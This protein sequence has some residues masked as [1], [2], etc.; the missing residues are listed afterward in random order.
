MKTDLKEIY[1]LLF[2]TLGPQHWWPAETPFEVIVGAVLVQNTN[3]QNVRQAIDALR[4]EELLDPHKIAELEMETL[5]TLI[6]PAGYFRIK[7]RR[8]RA[9][10]DWLIEQCDGELDELFRR[11]TA[12]LRKQL[13][14]VHGVGPETAD[15][16]LLYA[17]NLPVF[18]VDA[19]T[20]RIFT[21]HGWADAADTD[22]HR[23]QERIETLLPRDTQLFNEF[24][25]M[26]VSIG[27][28]YCKKSS[29]RCEDCPLRS[30]LPPGGAIEI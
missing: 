28:T 22:Y 17:G 13:L 6:R 8:L 24:H 25:A 15:S 5:E 18:V 19:Y 16:I 9:V 29:P 4:A 2:E 20:I 3:W 10:V 21:R 7:A 14:A 27:K 1:D 11:P 26:I 23:L 12:E 30:K